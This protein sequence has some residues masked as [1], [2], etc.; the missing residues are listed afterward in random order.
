MSSSLA[1]RVPRR[2]I[3][4]PDEPTPYGLVAL[5]FAGHV[6]AFSLS[7]AV[8]TYLGSRL[9]QSKIYVVNLVPDAPAAGSPKTFNVGS[10]TP[11]L[12]GSLAGIRGPLVLVGGGSD[13]LNV[14]N[15]GDTTFLQT[16][17]LTESNCP[18]PGA[19]GSCSA[20]QPT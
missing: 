19:A 17:T 12:G 16:G 6:L 3:A 2:F 1:Y 7:L 18:P 20:S 15:S 13:T 8:S 9:D 5:S 11:G 10:Q 4:F 14:D